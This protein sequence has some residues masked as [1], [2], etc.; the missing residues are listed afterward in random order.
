MIER[1]GKPLAGPAAQRHPLALLAVL[2]IEGSAPVTRDKLVALLWPEAGAAEARKRLRA[3]LHALR[4]ALG[5]EAVCSVGD[6]L[7]LVVDDAT[8]DVRAFEAAL[9]AGKIDAALRSYGGSFLDGFHLPASPEFDEWA[10]RHRDRLARACDGALEGLAESAEAGGDWPRA[11]DLWRERAARDPFSG[12]VAVRLITAL[13]RAG[14]RAAALW[15]GEG[16]LRLLEKE[17]GVE[18][19]PTVVA[20]LAR[21]RAAPLP[22]PPEFPTYG[23]PGVPEASVPGP[24]SDPSAAAHPRSASTAAGPPTS[25]PPAPQRGRRSRVRTA[26][27]LLA[28]GLPLGA[29]A[30]IALARSGAAPLPGPGPGSVERVLVLADIRGFPTDS[31]LPRAITEALRS[32][33]ARSSYARLAGAAEIREGLG[34]MRRSGGASI[35]GETAREIAVRMGFPGV[36]EGEVI[37]AGSGYILSARIVAADSGHILDS[38]RETAPDS[39]VLVD[40]IERLSHALRARAGESVEDIEASPP[41]ARV[42]TASLPALRKWAEA[43]RGEMLLDMD[44]EQVL[45]LLEEATRLDP[46]FATAWR[47]LGIVNFN[48]NRREAAL[49]AIERA[50]AVEARLPASQV[51]FTRIVHMRLVGDLAGVERELLARSPPDWNNAS[52]A[53]WARGDFAAA[54]RYALR[55]FEVAR[56]EG[57]QLRWVPY[58]NLGVAQLELGKIADARRT[59]DAS[60]ASGDPVIDQNLHWLI[61]FSEGA[62]DDAR[63]RGA[64]PGMRSVEKVALLQGRLAEAEGLVDEWMLRDPV[65]N[66][67]QLVIERALS[68]YLIA[69]DPPALAAADALVRSGLPQRVQEQPLAELALA[70]AMAGDTAAANRARAAYEERVPPSVRWN[71]AH[72]FHMVDGFA[73]LAE[74]RPDSAL[75]ALRRARAATPWTA[76]VDALLGR[77]YYWLQRPDS[78]IAAYTRYVETPWAYRAGVHT[79]FADPQLLVPTHERLAFLYAERGDVRGARKHAA[80]VVELWAD[81]DPELQPRVAAMRVLLSEG[82]PAALR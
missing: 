48:D 65:P 67:A 74:G 58:W 57:R 82:R 66:E 1:D 54:E 6:A 34:L 51:P 69:E 33:L 44:R 39:T 2:A 68:R 46:E 40:A 45:R 61:D 49:A 31:M 16:F 79:S 62:Y 59:A 63:R 53:A 71:E 32:D 36:I 43:L 30:A 9:A 27:T 13:E 24:L 25:G 15:H 4:E 41:L 78:A 5:A 64:N 75:A 12:R 80:R 42:I 73:A 17:L 70:H 8:I 19:E 22:T 47:W 20:L 14:E 77:A 60:P 56:E 26:A 3:S 38:F 10:D 29:G 81:A 72:V 23:P 11:S 37:R 55:A 21:I 35:D 7:R 50:L 18:P 52:D 28:L 76:P